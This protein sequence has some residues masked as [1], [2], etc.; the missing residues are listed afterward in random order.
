MT[1]KHRRVMPNTKIGLRK[2]T[3]TDTTWS[4]TK[5]LEQHQDNPFLS[6]IQELQRNSPGACP[7]ISGSIPAV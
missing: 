5:I 2:L 4:G 6:N 3:F 1:F 7:E